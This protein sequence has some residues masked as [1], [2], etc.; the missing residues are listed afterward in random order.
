MNNKIQE[1]LLHTKLM[2][3]LYVENNND[4]RRFTLELLSRFFDNI[5]VCI[6]G[7][8]GL[9]LFKKKKFNLI[10]TSQCMPVMSGIKMSGLIR[11]IDVDIPIFMLSAHNELYILEEAPDL[12]LTEYLL[13]PL[14]LVQLIKAF[15][16]IKEWIKDVR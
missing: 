8:D 14:S 5:S 6:N 7:E 9:E 3:I 16:N 15:E 13:K 1:I 11:E 4:A 10:I 2:H 12:N